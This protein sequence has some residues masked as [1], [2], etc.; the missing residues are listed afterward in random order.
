[1]HTH[2]Y[3]HSSDND[4]SP[5]STTLK[6]LMTQVHWLSVIHK[7]RNPQSY[8]IQYKTYLISVVDL[9]YL[10]LVL[11]VIQRVYGSHPDGIL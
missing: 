5:E 3:M 9:V 7:N 4:N 1:M 11:K 8:P 6:A 2:T 10:I